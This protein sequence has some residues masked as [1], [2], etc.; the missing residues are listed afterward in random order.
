MTEE[1]FKTISKNCPWRVYYKDN[2]YECAAIIDN[3]EW[4]YW[5]CQ[6]TGCAFVYWFE[7]MLKPINKAIDAERRRHAVYGKTPINIGNF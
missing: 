6:R 5:R 7:Q 4:G 1:K 3:Q 2:H